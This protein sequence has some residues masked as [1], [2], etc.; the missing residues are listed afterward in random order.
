MRRINLKQTKNHP[1]QTEK[2]HNYFLETNQALYQTER[3][4]GNG[5]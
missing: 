1:N 4:N 3:L 5:I 2:K